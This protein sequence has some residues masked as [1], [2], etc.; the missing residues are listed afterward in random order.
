MPLDRNVV[1]SWFRML[2][3]ESIRRGWGLAMLPGG[4]MLCRESFKFC[5]EGGEGWPVNRGSREPRDL[6]FSRDRDKVAMIRVRS[7]GVI[8]LQVW[9]CSSISFGLQRVA[10][11]Y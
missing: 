5:V 2:C 9:M 8:Y 1:A 3:R 10:G 7:S 11:T 6:G 4:S